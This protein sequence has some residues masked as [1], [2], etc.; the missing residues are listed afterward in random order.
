ML[1]ASDRILGLQAAVELLG[2]EAGAELLAA[3]LV[4]GRLR[5]FHAAVDQLLL[6]RAAFFV[7]NVYAGCSW[8]V[9]VVSRGEDP[10]A[11]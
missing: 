7:G 3:E 9:R 6:E 4:G 2:P 8:L 10:H 5:E 11:L 1:Q